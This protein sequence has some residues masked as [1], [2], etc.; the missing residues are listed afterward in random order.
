MCVHNATVHQV[1]LSEYEDLLAG[2]QA[3]AAWTASTRQYLRYVR[4]FYLTKGPVLASQQHGDDLRA[5][6]AVSLADAQIGVHG[7]IFRV[8]LSNTGSCSWPAH[9]S[10]R[11]GVFLGVHLYAPDGRLV[12]FDYHWQPLCQPARTVAPRESVSVAVQLPMLPPGLHVLEF[13]CVAS[14][15]AWFSQRGSKPLRTQIAIEPE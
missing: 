1:S 10:G 12:N 6:I 7:P 4:D 3:E 8:R 5:A 9:D 13:D 2:G 11:G 15:V 14:G